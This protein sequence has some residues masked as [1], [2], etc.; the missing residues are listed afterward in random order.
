MLNIPC[1]QATDVRE[2]QFLR[3]AIIQAIDVAERPRGNP[4]PRI[5]HPEVRRIPREVFF[6]Q[7][8]EFGSKVHSIR[9]QTD[10]P[11]LPLL[12]QALQQ[13]AIGAAYVQKVAIVGDGIED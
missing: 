8:K 1:Q 7:C 2:K 3:D 9:G 10:M 11:C 5:R 6:R 4:L 12:D 13:V